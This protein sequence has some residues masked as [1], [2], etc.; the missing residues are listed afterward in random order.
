MHRTIGLS[1]LGYRVR[2]VRCI[3]KCNATSWG[4]QHWRRQ[5]WGSGAVRPLDFHL[6]FWSLQSRT[7]SDI[8]LYAIAYPERI[9]TQAQATVNCMNFVIF[10]VGSPTNY[11]LL[12]SCPFSHQ[13]LATLLVVRRQ[14]VFQSVFI[15]KLDLLCCSGVLGLFDFCCPTFSAPSTRDRTFK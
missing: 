11:F 15:S 4:C 14:K 12:V 8:G 1:G 6:I 10:C 3:V 5:L 7:N 13:I 2:L 9:Y